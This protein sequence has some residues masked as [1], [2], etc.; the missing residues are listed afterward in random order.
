[1]EHRYIAK[2]SKRVAALMK[3]FRFFGY[4]NDHM[5]S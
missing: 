4:D 5:R 2:E 1:M 3:T